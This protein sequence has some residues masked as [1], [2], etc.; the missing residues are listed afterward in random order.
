MNTLHTILTASG[1]GEHPGPDGLIHCDS[2]GDARQTILHFG[3]QTHTVRCLCRCQQAQMDD[4]R[5]QLRRQEE[6]DCF[7]RMRS[8][9]MKE[10]ALRRC[11]FD[12]SEYDSAGMQV[13]RNYVAQWP[14][15]EKKGLG[16]LLWGPPGS[17]KTYAAACVANA[18]LDQGVPVLMSNFGRMLGAIPGPVS[19]EQTQTIDEWMQFPLLIIDDLGAERESAYAT[20]IIFA[21]I[22]S[23]YR[24]GKPLVI[25]TNLSMQQLENPGSVEKERIYQRV[26]ERC[27]P[28]CMKDVGIRSEKRNENREFAR[29]H[30]K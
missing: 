29:K 13:V 9:A 26:L 28:V 24:S 7:A 25:T 3:T 6:L 5:E 2:C 4:R 10:P 21:I 22:D 15:M 11:T 18:I 30:L 17:G 16:L 19:G 14:K 12:A 23:R 20:E 8:I 1:K 27:T